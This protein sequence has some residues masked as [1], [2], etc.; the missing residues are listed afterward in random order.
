M[1]K[2]MKQLDYEFSAEMDGLVHG[3]T[4]GFNYFE[5]KRRLFTKTWDEISQLC[6]GH[7]LSAISGVVV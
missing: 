3:L 5:G 7:R 2:L 1:A 6:I 4:G